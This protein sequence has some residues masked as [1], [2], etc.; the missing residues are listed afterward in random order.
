VKVKHFLK[1]G[2]A[3]PA[4]ADGLEALRPHV[5]VPAVL[6]RGETCIRLEFLQLRRNGDWA[7]LA[8]MLPKLHPVAGP[9]FGW[10]IG[11]APG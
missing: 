3:A 11:R 2:A 4:E 8:R 1:E 7:A 6:E 10:K 5:R 9:R